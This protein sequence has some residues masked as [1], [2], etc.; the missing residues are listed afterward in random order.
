MDW[1]PTD[2]RRRKGASMSEELVRACAERLCANSWDVYISE[3]NRRNWLNIADTILADGR[4]VAEHPD[5]GELAT[6]EWCEAVGMKPHR[7][8]KSFGVRNGNGVEVDVTFH[9]ATTA[10]WS[11]D[12]KVKIVGV[13][14]GD[15]RRLCAALGI[16]LKEQA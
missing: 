11:G 6:P 13:T 3:P 15:V 4:A 9:N 14:R 12:H 16:K 1:S 7:S 10:L 2:G 8:G 5:E